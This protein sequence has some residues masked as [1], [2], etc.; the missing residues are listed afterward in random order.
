[1]SRSKNKFP[2]KATILHSHINLSLVFKVAMLFI[3]ILHVF[4][5]PLD[6]LSRSTSGKASFEWSWW[7]I[8]HLSKLT[9]S[10]NMMNLM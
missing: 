8:L 10:S 2:K 7:H 5:M 9:P 1:M 6:E 4:I 3:E